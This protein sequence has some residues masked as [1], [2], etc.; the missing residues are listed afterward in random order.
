MNRALSSREKGEYN[1]VQ[2]GRNFVGPL[3]IETIDEEKRVDAGL[4]VHRHVITTSDPGNV[5]SHRLVPCLVL[6]HRNSLPSDCPILDG[7]TSSPSLSLT[8]DHSLAR[9]VFHERAQT[10][11][12]RKERV[13]RAFAR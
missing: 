3:I 6:S 1:R 9:S 7:F 13:T 10:N 5:F 12:Y 8:R 11:E 4:P 2:T